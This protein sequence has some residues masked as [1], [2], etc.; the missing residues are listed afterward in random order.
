MKHYLH[1]IDEVFSEVSSSSAGLSSAEAQARLERDGKN[2]LNEAKKKSTLARFVDQLKDPMIIILIV[3]AVISAVT[4]IIEG[5]QS[6]AGIEFPTDVIIIL[7][8]TFL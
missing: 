4:G 5:I 3:A 6:G 1:S 7:F 2:K 8:V